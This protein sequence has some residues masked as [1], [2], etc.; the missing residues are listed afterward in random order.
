M[1][2]ARRSAADMIANLDR[3]VYPFADN[4]FDCI[5]CNHVIEHLSDVI[6]TFE[7]LWRIAKTDASIEGATPHFSSAASYAD[8]THRHHFGVRT[9]EF[10]AASS[11]KPPGRMRRL[12]E[13]LYH[14]GELEN[15]PAVGRRFE[16]IE[17]RLKFNP[18]L[19]KVGIEWAANLYPEFYEAFFAFIIPA[20]DIIFRLKV[21]K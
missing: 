12:M 17:V 9:F 21:I 3:S 15:I 20:R 5:V 16:R 13:C 18:L 14:A 10:L 1:D 4:T 8:P 7:E 19:Q 6:K 2:I 11:H